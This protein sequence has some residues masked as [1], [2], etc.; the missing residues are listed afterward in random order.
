MQTV[1]IG[2]V[3]ASGYSGLELSRI[4]ALHPHV[5]LKLLGS[6]K[7]AGE[8]AARQA[9]LRG[10]AGKLKYAPQERC[11]ELGRECAAVFLATPAEASLALAPVLLG[12][13]VRVI[14]LSGSFRLRDAGLYP[15]FYAFQHPRPDLLQEAFYGLPELAPPPTGTRLVA[16]PG[17]YPTGASLALAPLVEA[18]VLDGGRLIVD[19]ASGVTGAGRRAAEEYSFAEIDGDFRAYKVLR[20]QHQPEIAQTLDRSVTFTAHLLPIRRGILSTCYG[21]LQPGRG[22]AELRAALMHKYAGAPFVEVLESPDQ[23][24]LKAVIGTNRCQVA[25]AADG[26]VV[27]AI[28]AIDNLVKGAAGQAVQ[29]LNL[30]M[31]WPQTAGLDTLRGFHP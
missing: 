21:R 10:A 11:A 2:V 29:N 24:T 13:G 22:A 3:G 20:H 7:W 12:A 25:V 17:C 5:E 1:P 27:V 18:G 26:D 8:T 31:G 16:N 14:D 30:V 9:G 4:L 19:A 28:S 15:K 23:L 6:D